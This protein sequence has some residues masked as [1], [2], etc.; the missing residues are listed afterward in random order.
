[1]CENIPGRLVKK[2]CGTMRPRLL[3]VTITRE[4]SQFLRTLLGSILIGFSHLTRYIQKGH[5]FL[6]SSTAC[7]FFCFVRSSLLSKSTPWLCIN[8]EGF[9]NLDFFIYCLDL[10]MN[11]WHMIKQ[12]FVE[13]NSINSYDVSP[14]SLTLH[15]LRIL[16]FNRLPRQ[17][18]LLTSI[19]LVL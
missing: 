16:F 19:G 12:G 11:W 9:T 18:L 17:L 5:L 4:K 8:R 15:I 1:M 2:S 14:M 7:R 10:S 13:S 3:P 6:P